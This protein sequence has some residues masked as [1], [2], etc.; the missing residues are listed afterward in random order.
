MK[1]SRGAWP[2]L[3]MFCILL[4]LPVVVPQTRFAVWLDNQLLDL[5]FS[6]HDRK[7]SGE[8]VFV[9]IDKTS[10]D[11]IGTWPWP[12]TVHADLIDR[13]VAADVHDIYLDIDFSTPST[14]VAD[15]RL[16]EALADAGG[17]VML[18]LFLQHD[19]AGDRGTVAASKPIPILEEHA[20]LAFAN[21]EMDE[22]GLIRHFALSERFDGDDVPSA[23]ALLANYD[24]KTQKTVLIDYSIDPLSVPVFSVRDILEGNV[25]KEALE[26]R[27]VV[28]G[29]FAT[30]L[31]DFF[32]VPL[33][34]VISGPMLHILAA[35]TLKQK[36]LLTEI[37]L[38]APS[39]LLCGLIMI[40]VLRFHHQ[41]LLATGL[42]LALV[43]IT[44]ET[45]AF[46]LQDEYR[47]VLSTATL[48]L[49]LA[50]GL[51]ILMVEK[52]DIETFLVEVANAENRTIRRIL[53]RVIADSVDAIVVVDSRFRI[54]DLSRTT[55]GLL[56]LEK[57]LHRGQVIT[58]H[59]PPELSAIL[60]RAVSAFGESPGAVHTEFGRFSVAGAR[61]AA[62]Y[63]DV[64]K[65][66]RTLDATVTISPFDL[67]L[68][69]GVQEQ[70][71][72]LASV[73]IRDVT[74]RHAYETKLMQLSQYD[75]L[76]GLL[77]RRELVVRLEQLG[78]PSG[79]FAINLHRFGVLNSTL[80]R[81]LG[82]RLLQAVAKRLAAYAGDEGLVGRI[83]GDVFAIVLPGDYDDV[84]L[85]KK[86]EELL[87][88]FDV[89]VSLTD[90]QVDIT[91]RI[92]ASAGS[93]GEGCG[94]KWLS[95]AELALDDAKTVS[96]RGWR[97]YDPLA[98]D[99]QA[100]SR[101]LEGELRLGLEDQQFFL[102]YQPQVDLKTG[103]V[104]G[105]EAL[106]RWQ[107]PSLGII[108]P[109][110]FIGIA[111]ANGFICELGRW[112][113]VEACRAACDWPGDMS[114]AVN[115][116]PLQ[117]V[118]D[119]LVKDV[120]QALL[121]TGL[122]ARRLHLEITESTFLDRTDDLL[123]S[124]AQLRKM[125]VTIALDDFGT[126]YSSLAYLAGFP[127]DKIKIDQSFIRK[128]STDAASQAIV[129]A[130]AALARG[131]DLKIV[132]EG[133]E[134]DIEWTLLRQLGCEEGQGYFFGKPQTSQELVALYR[135]PHWSDKRRAS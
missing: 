96:G 124:L 54:V 72:F 18:P 131:L 116:S 104:I 38:L 44:G 57:P 108:S 25:A 27:S 66:S 112:M 56:G 6:L 122:P 35:E 87:E 95:D 46:L 103:S 7:A 111:E 51:L 110:E 127:I 91:A 126:G 32:A 88:L 65:G 20:W 22:G 55:P 84:R 16:A 40:Y 26:G 73:T 39:L 47:A 129:I 113:L 43:V 41:P 115:V 10:I 5:R 13:L 67:D 78:Q 98:A 109:S 74:S 75:E 121:L 31:G 37:P 36:G 134:G 59:A 8:I 29:A 15:N 100:R 120:E 30:E 71:E 3:V 102:L 63:D 132:C 114:V 52:I 82:D 118:K 79:V 117:F 24:G 93:P 80:G 97:L 19:S 69:Q 60:R 92:G 1:E 77:N 106:L 99:R 58:E 11:S 62:S 128:M 135:D 64:A 49:I 119:D 68:P 14:S 83:G 42:G 89:P 94:S 45:L 33:H 123:K 9:A 86:A 101:R 90:S 85:A 21:V 53:K 130:V 81:E 4:A 105:A 17:G 50:F 12:R 61:Y 70:H 125:G 107:H 48:W 133:I 2:R 34:G 23:A 28:V 76:T